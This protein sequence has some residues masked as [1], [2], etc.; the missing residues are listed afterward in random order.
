MILIV[1]AVAAFGGVCVYAC[2][3]TPHLC[4][5]S[6]VFSLPFGFLA[7]KKKISPSLSMAALFRSVF[8]FKTGKV[9][10]GIGE[11]QR[12]AF[13]LPLINIFYRI[14][15]PAFLEN[16]HHRLVTVGVDVRDHD[17]YKRRLGLSGA[18]YDGP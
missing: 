18:G 6:L 3:R 11:K 8:A 12:L 13:S 5:H 7:E 2:E 14:S 1:S 9:R 4:C 10:P 17:G 16:H 15:I